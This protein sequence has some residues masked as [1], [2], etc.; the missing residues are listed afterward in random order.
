MAG[1]RQVWVTRARPG[2]DATAERLRAL[3]FAPLVAPVLAVRA[4]EGATPDLGGVC[5]LAF[6]SANGV[7]AFAALSPQR[8]LGVFA[9]GDATAE[10]AEALGFAQ[11]LSADGD[12]AALAALIARRWT[13][14]AG[15][16]LHVRGR[17][18]AGD[19]A[20]A[21]AAEG[22]PAQAVTLYETIAAE[23]LPAV[24]HQA[25]A[26]LDAVL[27]H[28][29]KAGRALA[30]LLAEP[31]RQGRTSAIRVIGL[32]AACLAPLERVVPAKL[33][34]AERPREDALLALLRSPEGVRPDPMAD[35]AS[36]NPE[37]A[38]GERLGDRPPIG[39]LPRPLLGPV[40]WLLVVAAALCIGAGAVIGFYGSKLFPRPAR[41][42]HV[43]Q[44]KY[45]A[46]WVEP[47]QRP[48]RTDLSRRLLT[49]SAG[50]GPTSSGISP[51]K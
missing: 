34:A 27:V 31:A 8:D 16:L 33:Q 45:S 13:G 48:R 11:V 22:V 6:T 37:E 23:T 10:A 47:A 7:R 43:R 5:A 36:S 18:T 32:S 24:V 35:S 1:D 21:L 9:V 50:A 3:G 12:V 39:P 44:W 29:P 25:L 17:D 26:T 42:N 4:I 41:I 38:A 49:W 28:S 46:A 40:F 19:L 30:H 20:G 51:L 2:A 14:R 15:A